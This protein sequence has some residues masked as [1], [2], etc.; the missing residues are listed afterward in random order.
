MIMGVEFVVNRDSKEP[1]DPA[2]K[3]HNKI[4]AVAMKNGLLCYGM[5][6]TIDGKR[7]DHILLAPP[8]NLNDAQQKELV[9]KFVASV[10]VSLPA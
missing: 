4:Q 3:I 8:Y 5:G 10:T 2:S 6:G 1:F 9:D 7:G